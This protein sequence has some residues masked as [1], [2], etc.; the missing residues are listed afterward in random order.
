MDAWVWVVIVV[1]VV[2]VLAVVVWAISQRRRSQHLKERFGPEY[3]RT[4]GE[5]D[6]RRE[7]EEELL[8]REKRHEELEIQP[9]GA[10]AQARYR[11]EWQTVQARFVDDPEGAVREAD[12]LVARVMEERGYPSD[13]DAEE[14]AADLSVEHADVVGQYRRGHALLSGLD[15]AEDPTESLRQSMRCFRT[16]FEDLL[17]DREVSQR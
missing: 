11:D 14:R 7:A 13:G 1:A 16:A 3:E 2:I 6:K 8:A 12:T 10:A 17:E 15:E 4:V 5:A 9:L